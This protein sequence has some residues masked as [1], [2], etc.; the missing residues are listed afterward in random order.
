MRWTLNTRYIKVSANQ[1]N[2][3][4]VNARAAKA[5]LSFIALIGCET[6][7]AAVSQKTNNDAVAASVEV[8]VND[9]P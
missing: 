5:F 9:H 2:A 3:R 6:G 4:A 1:S 8:V 7:K